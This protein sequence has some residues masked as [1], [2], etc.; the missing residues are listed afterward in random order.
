MLSSPPIHAGIQAFCRLSVNRMK[1][2]V[3]LLAA[4]TQDA[5]A[6]KLPG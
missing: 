1:S 2:I 5:M 3:F 6:A 4:M